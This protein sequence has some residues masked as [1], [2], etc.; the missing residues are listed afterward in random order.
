M[1]QRHHQA[2]HVLRAYRY[3]LLHA[4]QEWIDLRSGQLLLLEIDEDHAVESDARAEN[5][6][7][8]F[9]DAAA[10][11]RAVSLRTPG[12]VEAIE[13]YWRQSQ[14]GT[15]ARHTLLCLT[16]AKAAR[17]RGS[18]LPEGR[19]RH[20]YCR[21]CARR[22]DLSKE[23]ALL[24]DI[25]KH[26]PLG[27]W[28]KSN[29]SDEDLRSRLL[30][31]VEFVLGAPDDAS[32]QS[33]IRERLGMIYLAKGHFETT[34]DTALPVLLDKVFVAA[35]SKDTADRR[36][37]LADLHRSIEESIPRVGA[38]TQAGLSQHARP[39]TGVGVTSLQLQT[40]L[41]D[42]SEAVAG[43]T[44]EALQNQIIWLY[45]PNGVGKST[46]AKL[47]GK[48]LGGS[49]LVCESRPFLADPDIRLSL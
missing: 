30:K 7:I 32:L 12:V 31:R 39:E 25:F 18:R 22:A 42:R 37:T 23:R 13:R 45:G 26:S 44:S 38:L 14:E 46:L 17:E 20:I 36:L 11:A 35:S 4:L 33:H 28:L 15:D 9:S 1:Q 47:L 8:K 24:S 34:A 43:L 5:T 10:G 29:P 49:W 6:Q 21:E 3:Q 19:A 2:D 40:G 27:D 16:H 41:S 48:S